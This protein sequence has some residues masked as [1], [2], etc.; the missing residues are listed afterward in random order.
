MPRPSRTKSKTKVKVNTSPAVPKGK[1]E[2]IVF[3][4]R[5]NGGRAKPALTQSSNIGNPYARTLLNPEFEE[6]HGVP[7]Q[8]DQPSHKFTTVTNSIVPL[9]PQ[10]QYSLLVQPDL[11]SSYWTCWDA[12]KLDQ[13]ILFD[14]EAP[15]VFPGVVNG[16]TSY[17][18]HRGKLLYENNA[19]QDYVNDKASQV[20]WIAG[21]HISPSSETQLVMP[22]TIAGISGVVPCEGCGFT[23]Y[24]AG[25]DGSDSNSFSIVFDGID[26]AG[27]PLTSVGTSAI[28]L[29]SF[30]VTY[31]ISSAFGGGGGAFL[32]KVT[33]YQNAQPD[34]TYIQS[35]KIGMASP[36]APSHLLPFIYTSHAVDDFETYRNDFIGVRPVGCSG[37]VTYR[38]KA[39]EGGFIA[40]RRFQGVES[41]NLSQ[42]P[43]LPYQNLA[44]RPGTYDGQVN[45]GAYSFWLPQDVDGTKFRP[46]LTELDDFRY[47][48]LAYAGQVTDT[49]SDAVLRIRVATAWEGITYKQM[50]HLSGTLVD[51]DQITLA[52]K[53]LSTL[54]S[55][56][57][58]DL[59]WAT[60]ADYLKR[61]AKAAGKVLWDNRGAVAGAVGAAARIPP[62][63]M[64][65]IQRVLAAV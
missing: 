14:A 9:G 32:T 11:Q 3:A 50:Y 47:G 6:N 58:N 1:Q 25:V 16:Y 62:P 5:K 46:V 20:L 45:T 63:L 57:E 22:T 61:G 12:T 56:M 7:D 2:V 23:V 18:D 52:L 15:N 54:P 64:T 40:A 53:T 39:L 37:L 24:A 31:T 35:I 13:V 17:H 51:P 33:L 42:A 59:H 38:G 10:G 30:P 48:Y 60:I 19:F 36:T 26:A 43:A 49:T 34:H 65:V 21:D 44:S 8:F 55:A 4:P 29:R 41:P 27:N 28:N